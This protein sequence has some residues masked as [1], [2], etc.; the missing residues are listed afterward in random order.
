MPENDAKAL[1]AFALFRVDP[2]SQECRE[3]IHQSLVE[4]TL[5]N[6]DV[7]L[8][9]DNVHQGI[10]DILEQPLGISKEKC[11]AAIKECIQQDRVKGNKAKY[12]LR[13]ERKN[14]LGSGKQDT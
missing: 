9:V 3:L 7:P 13:Q 11:K 8:I 4:I 10:L 6:S 2:R 5:L 12:S 1:L 14:I